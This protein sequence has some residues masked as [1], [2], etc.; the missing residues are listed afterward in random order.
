MRFYAPG[1]LLLSGEYAVLDGALA[2]SCPSR[3]GQF[4]ELFPT[5]DSSTLKW[6]ALTED[7]QAWLQVILNEQGEILQSNDRA[8]AQLI[9]DLLLDAFEGELPVGQRAET[10][11]NFKREWGL[12]SSSTLIALI[13]NWA[14]KD[15][16][17]LFFKHLKG[18]GYD[19]ATALENKAIQYQL[20]AHQKAVWKETCLPE[21]L[22]RS[23]FLYLGEKQISSTEVLRYS[24]LKRDPHLAQ[25][26]S[27]LSE[28]LLGISFEEE[29]ISWMA[30]HEELTGRLIQQES[31]REKRFPHLQGGFK[32]LGAWGG[33][34]VWIMPKGDDLNY[35]RQEGYHEVFPFGELLNI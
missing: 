23:Y 14:Q 3:K 6:H 28:A 8:K 16:M 26:I 11:L 12:G 30:K 24:S 1:K 35:L 19:V 4:L 29:L 7:G 9:R 13:A 18:S 20:K 25:S 10:R 34:F 27:Q 22:Q 32:S 15:A 33:D 31:H 2:I 5:K 21:V 17:N